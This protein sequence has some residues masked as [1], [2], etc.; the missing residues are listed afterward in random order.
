MEASDR[1][2]E[3]IPSGLASL[4]IEADE[5]DMA[6]MKAAHQMFWPGILGLISADLG[7]VAPEHDPDLSKAP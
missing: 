4:G 7:D 2:D 1:A 5:V 6:V 3:F